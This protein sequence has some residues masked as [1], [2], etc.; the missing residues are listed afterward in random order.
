M[1]KKLGQ[2]LNKLIPASHQYYKAHPT[3]SIPTPK[4]EKFVPFYGTKGG[5]MSNGVGWGG[6]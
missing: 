1:L 2:K 3:T 6:K 4:K 5:K